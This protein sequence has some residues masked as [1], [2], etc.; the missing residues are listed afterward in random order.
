[1][2]RAMSVVVPSV[3]VLIAGSSSAVAQLGAFPWSAPT[4]TAKTLPASLESAIADAAGGSAT[5][6]S[7]I[8]A[9]AVRAIESAP[10][11]FA[12]DTTPELWAKVLADYDLRPPTLGPGDP[13][14]DRFDLDFFKWGPAGSSGGGFVSGTG[15]RANLTYSFAPDNTAWGLNGTIV[16]KG[17][18]DMEFG[19]S[20]AFGDP[21]LGK[22][23]IRQAIANW[24]RYGGLSYTEVADSGIP[25]DTNSNRRTTVGDIRF[26][27]LFWGINGLLAYNGFPTTLGVSSTFGGGDMCMNTAYF[28]EGARFSNP[29]LDYRNFRNVIAHEHGHGLGFIHQV[30]CVGTKLMEPQASVLTDMVQL[31]D[32]R[33][34]N[35]N[36]G[37]RYSGN[38]S[39]GNAVNLGTLS[40]P[41]RSVALR[42]LSTNGF[43]DNGTNPP[44]TDYFKFTLTQSQQV[45]INV[46]PTGESYETGQQASQCTGTTTIYNSKLFGDLAFRLLD[47]NGNTITTVNAASVGVFESLTSNLG[48]GTYFVQVWDNNA[49]NVTGGANGN[50]I[51]QMY[52]LE[53]LSGAGVF[54]EPYANAGL[55]K[56]VKANAPAYFMG[57]V[58]SAPTETRV[59]TTISRYE[60]DLD[61]DGVFETGVLPAASA[62]KP[63]FTYPS[64]GVYNVSLR[65]VDSNG[66]AGTDTLAVTVFGATTQLTGTSQSASRGRVVPFTLT[67]KNLKN[68]SAASMVTVSGS[69]VSVTGTPVRNALGTQVTGLSY[70]IASNA[71]LGS[72][73][74]SVSNADGSANAALLTVAAPPCPGDLNLDGFVDDADFQ[75]FVV[76]YDILECSDPA[77][78]AAC[79]SDLDGDGAVNDADFGVFVVGYDALLCP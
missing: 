20:I 40:S 35:R 77:M 3:L 63:T 66:K 67:G 30:P 50:T 7:M 24:R 45:T 17:F 26:G 51:V 46:N 1:M 65:V 47:S 29:D 6:A 60:W 79:P 76:A 11:C 37:D 18:S 15:L 44:G 56:R 68:L 61:G 25:M 49:A 69:G 39:F 2:R 10:L 28:N 27:G 75:I 8:R 64:N 31:D 62:P 9:R 43:Y 36:Y 72:R 34:V 48:A 32:R 4:P 42:D 22:E 23:Y 71:A 38:F 53:L 74:V 21:E 5:R 54:T 58:N 52:D 55:A 12:N 78:P 57:D 19:L 70:V 33:G 14:Q 41:A 16:P 73:T 59:P 13:F